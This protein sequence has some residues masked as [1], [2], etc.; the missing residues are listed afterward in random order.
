MLNRVSSLL[1]LFGILASYVVALPWPLNKF[2]RVRVA[3]NYV[4][5]VFTWESESNMYVYT[6]VDG[7]NFDLVKGPAYV[8]AST[9][10]RDPSPLL[11]TDGYWYMSYTTSWES[12]NFAIARS[13]NLLDWTLYATIPI[14]NTTVTRTWAPELFKDPSTGKIHIIVSLGAVTS[15]FNPYVLTA[16]DNTLSTWSTPKVMTGMG[17]N[18]I[19]TFVIPSGG[20]YH[21]FAKN[22]NTKWIEHAVSNSLTGPY[23]FVQTGNHSGWD[24]LEGPCLTTLQDGTYRIFADAYESSVRKYMYADSKDLYTW[25]GYAQ[26]PGGLSGFVRHGTVRRIN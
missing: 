2:S 14:T 22:E 21:V 24:H 17:P 1:L 16:T 10:I 9:L 11:H 20:Q 19:D 3:Y 4:F 6:S 23:T 18:Y 15:N 25:T 26:V 8:P 13:L 5:T 7:T 12:R